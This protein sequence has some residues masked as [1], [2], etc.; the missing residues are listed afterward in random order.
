MHRRRRWASAAWIH[1]R[2]RH[3]RGSIVNPLSH[4]MRI[5]P[6]PGW[7]SRRS[8]DGRSRAGID[9]LTG[10]QRDRKADTR[11]NR[12]RQFQAFVRD[13]DDRTR[14]LITGIAFVCHSRQPHREI[15]WVTIEHLDTNMRIRC[16]CGERRRPE[17]VQLK[18][19]T[20]WLGDEDLTR[21][22]Q[23]GIPLHQLEPA[24]ADFYESISD[25]R[26]YRPAHIDPL[27]RGAFRATPSSVKAARR[28]K[29]TLRDE[30]R[31]SYPD[32]D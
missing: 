24:E 32:A 21:A 22:M 5:P 28:S 11:L 6:P 3:R 17:E 14:R 4:P 19:G 23:L 18:G 29:S 26:G 13:M 27:A 10:R 25:D 31:S 30:Y 2:L 20:W 9:R 7:M 12:S 16:A 8:R 1:L 15:E